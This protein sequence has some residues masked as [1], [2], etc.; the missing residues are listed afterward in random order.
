M[1][2]ELMFSFFKSYLSSYT[3]K[4]KRF[5]FNG[6]TFQIRVLDVKSTKGRMSK[7][8]SSVNTLESDTIQP[9]KGTHLSLKI[10]Y[11]RTY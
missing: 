4:T 7:T 9:H 1:L 8:K 6:S 11:R 2:L 5:F 3:W 10:L